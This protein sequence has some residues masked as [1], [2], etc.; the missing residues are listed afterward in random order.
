[1][2]GLF[3][4]SLAGSVI[5]THLFISIANKF[6][7]YDYPEKRKM[8]SKPMPL[9]GGLAVY[10]SFI[11]ALL[12]NFH[13]SWELK[14]MIIAASFVMISGLLDDIKEL[15]A[16][17]RLIIQILCALLVI[18][19]GIRLKLVTDA[20]P[21]GFLIDGVITV[22][23]IV[24]ITNAINFLDGLDGLAAGLSFIISATFFVIAYQTGQTYFA[25]LNIALAGACLGFLF[26]NFKPAKIFLGDAGSSF[27]GFSLAVLA[28]MG[29]WSQTRPV[30]AFSIPLLVLA[31]PIF[32]VIY[33]TV[34]RIAQGKVRSFREWIEYVGKD[35]LH[36]RLLGLGFTE[37]QTVFI[38]YLINIVFA[39]GVLVLK[40][41]DNFQALLLV[42][43]GTFILV[44]VTV[45]MI[46]G[47]G[48]L[49]NMDRS[50]DKRSGR[51][52]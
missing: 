6:N 25:F 4:F 42:T 7:I 1:M 19:F 2:L 28:V 3:I 17:G 16:S 46:A 44:L 52:S 24:G 12:V 20:V 49:E 9:L 13:F 22:I 8:H 36:H 38:I 31:I 27:L 50:G 40:K 47:R 14:G 21:Y 37:R 29:E 23:W 48:H 41:A 10:V 39:L 43:Q 45:L 11:T 32:D 35:H 26:F 18:A 34:S 30:V 51:L 15:S 5:F 33:I